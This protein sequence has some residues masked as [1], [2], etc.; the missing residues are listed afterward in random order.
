MAAVLS[1][2]L[3]S[4]KQ[5]SIYSILHWFKSAHVHFLGALMKA[6]MSGLV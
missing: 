5:N 2:S 3:S 1:C 6:T 4:D